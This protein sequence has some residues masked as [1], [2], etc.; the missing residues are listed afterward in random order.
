MHPPVQFGIIEGRFIPECEIFKIV[1]ETMEQRV[2]QNPSHKKRLGQGL[3]SGGMAAMAM[4]PF[5]LAFGALAGIG[6]PAGLIAAV[7]A[8]LLAALIPGRVNYFVGPTCIVFLVFSACAG[9]YGLPVALTASLLAGVLVFAALLLRADRLLQWIPAPVAGGFTIGAALVMTILQTNNYFGINATGVSAV[10]MLLSYR[11]FGFHANWRTV[12]YGTIVLV[13]MITYP[14]KFK[15]LHQKIPA[16]FVSLVIAL[17]LH[18][19]LVPSAKQS[20]VLEVGAF[21]HTLSGSGGI[22]FGGFTVAPLGG[23]ILSALAIALSILVCSGVSRSAREQQAP[24]A[25]LLGVGNMLLP[26]FGGMPVGA[27]QAMGEQEERATRVAPLFS[28]VL[29][30]AAVLLLGGV[31]ERIPLSVLAVILIVTMWEKLD[32]QALKTVFG[33]KNPAQII[34]FFL[35]AAATVF[36]ELPYVMVLFGIVTVVAALRTMYCRKKG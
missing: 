16:Q 36:L 8:G 34:L 13:L 31:F 6:M 27:A 24:H 20:P 12:L 32:F 11:S 21:A 15:K 26:L 10:D 4:L 1:R 9:R 28:S 33:G 2:T 17:G 23:L 14:R 19:C 29:M 30:L 22:L 7:G 25:I 18:L 35:C 5:A 3:A